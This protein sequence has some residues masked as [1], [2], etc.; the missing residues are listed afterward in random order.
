LGSGGEFVAELEVD[1]IQRKCQIIGVNLKGMEL[2]YSRMEL[3]GQA[4]L[5]KRSRS[6]PNL[7]VIAPLFI[8]KDGGV[9]NSPVG[10]QNC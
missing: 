4:E 6:S 7:S 8:E 2:N 3:Y 5:I 1:F 10:R 9:E